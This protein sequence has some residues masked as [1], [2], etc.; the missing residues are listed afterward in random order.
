MIAAHYSKD[1]VLLPTVSDTPRISSGL[2]KDYFAAFLR[3]PL[4][5]VTSGHGVTGEVG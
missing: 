5:V 2:I 4:G 1:S 3:K